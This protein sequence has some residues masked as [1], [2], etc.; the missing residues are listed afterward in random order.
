MIFVLYSLGCGSTS[1]AGPPPPS[2]P[3]AGPPPLPAPAHLHAVRAPLV[4]QLFWDAVDGATSYVIFAV[5]DSPGA[6]A[7]ALGE[8]TTNGVQIGFQF[9]IPAT[10]SV[11]AKSANGIG[12]A[13]AI[14][15]AVPPLLSAQVVEGTRVVLSWIA[16]ARLGT[17]ALIGR[18]ADAASLATV[19]QVQGGSVFVDSSGTP[20]TTYTYAVRLDAGSVIAFSSLALVK[21]GP[22]A[23][24]GV[25][26][27]ALEGHVQFTWTPVPGAVRYH[28]DYTSDGSLGFGSGDVAQPTGGLVQVDPGKFVTAVVRAVDENG[29]S[30]F[31]SEPVT[32]RTLP[33]TVLAS[34]TSTVDQVSFSWPPAAGSDVVVVQRRLGTE[35]TFTEI[36]RTTGTTFTDAAPPKWAVVD[37]RFLALD[38]AHGLSSV[39]DDII[40]LAT[41]APDQVNLGPGTPVVDPTN[42]FDPRP[43][44]PGQSFLVERSGQLMGIEVKGGA[45]TLSVSNGEA[46]LASGIPPANFNFLAFGDPLRP[47]LVSGS[48]YDVSSANIFVSAG[49]T[50]RFEMEGGDIVSTTPGDAYPA[51]SMSVLGAFDASSD[52]VFKTF[53]RTDAS[54]TAPAIVFSQ[55][56][57]RAAALTW[58]GAPAAD[59]YD[60]L[61][62]AADGSL[63]TATTTTNTSAVID[64]LLPG[65][66]VTFVVRAVLPTGATVDS[67]PAVV[68]LPPWTI[69]Q[70][71]LA[72]VFESRAAPDFLIGVPNKS[73]SGVI[74]SFTA[75]RDGQLAGFE[76]ALSDGGQLQVDVFDAAQNLLGT[77][78]LPGPHARV[79]EEPLSPVV[80][81]EGF[82]DLTSLGIQV[83]AGDQLRVRVATAGGLRLRAC[84]SCTLAAAT[85]LDLSGNPIP[86]ELLAFKTFLVP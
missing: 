59:H 57:S 52:L 8:V 3:D 2:P 56:G 67:Q 19:G 50:L 73:S 35:T 81:R 14:F 30:S 34:L 43:P 74:Q 1:P 54:Q 26:G 16:D 22:A 13:A 68:G 23:P 4:A 71:N 29:I 70:A 48:Y 32:I 44:L 10:F 21:T 55:G 33:A 36:G 86:G 63:S 77:A 75:G 38:T 5:A 80:A 40:T 18:G 6:T 42:P 41:E 76:V 85:L 24:L 64:G 83:K 66:D 20:S 9:D 46:R 12:A 15:V 7:R 65:T 27:T 11:S 17:N 51:G 60:V 72:D 28:V 69:D 37:Y 31:P 25:A 82:V 49:E 58:Q 79:A 62:V 45:S 53:V 39:P 84:S 47:Q 78:Q 61:L